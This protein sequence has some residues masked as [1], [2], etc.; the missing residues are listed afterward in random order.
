MRKFFVAAAV[1]VAF[2]FGSAS[3]ADAA[4]RLRVESGT[5]TGP[6]VV[7]TDN[8]AGDQSGTVDAIAYSTGVSE[9]IGPFT[10]SFTL[11]TK[12]PGTLV[13]PGFYEGMDLNNVT[14]T[15]SGAG[16][17]RLILESDDFGANTPDGQLLLTNKIGG[18]LSA[19]GGS[20]LTSTSYLSDVSDMPNFGDDVSPSGAL[21]P[22]PGSGAGSIGNLATSVGQTFGPGAFS[23]TVST[24]AS[25]TGGYSLY[26]VITVTFTGAGSV[27]LDSVTATSPAPAGL[28]M[29]LTGVPVLGL[30]AWIRRRRGLATA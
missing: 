19:P 11:G 18:V 9:T 16:T 8:A 17:L 22:I 13:L 4:F 20:S 3:S 5:T 23:G 27:S 2:L 25:K 30:G 28:L 24:V 15:T 7:I 10:L 1:A 14:I 21:D 6:G 29:A 26:N 12:T